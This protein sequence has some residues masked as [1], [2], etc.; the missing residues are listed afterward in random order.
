M[1]GYE[2]MAD[3]VATFGKEIGIELNVD[4]DNYCCLSINDEMALHMK[5]NDYFDGII[6]Y[7][8]LGEVP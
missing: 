3:A 1:S 2:L 6:F 8:E 7:S 4:A 5:F